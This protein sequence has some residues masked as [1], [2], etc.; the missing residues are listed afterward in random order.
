[1]TQRILLVARPGQAKG[2][3]LPGQQDG[4]GPHGDE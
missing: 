2:N 3:M 1:V 4:T